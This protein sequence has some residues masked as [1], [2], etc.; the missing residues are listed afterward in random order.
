M[1]QLAIHSS[2]STLPCPKKAKHIIQTNKAIIKNDSHHIND[3]AKI[4]AATKETDT[5]STTILPTFDAVKVQDKQLAISTDPANWSFLN[6]NFIIY[7]IYK[8][9]R[10]CSKCMYSVAYTFNTASGERS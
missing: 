3:F 8:Y 6:D 9:R 1:S 4:V 7:F 10:L 2:S 5:C